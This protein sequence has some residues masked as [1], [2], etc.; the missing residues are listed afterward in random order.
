MILY[1]AYSVIQAGIAYRQYNKI[2]GNF[3]F[4]L[5]NWEMNAIGSVS[6]V[7]ISSSCPSGTETLIKYTWP[8][9]TPGCYCSSS[10][11]LFAS[12]C[13]E[14][15]LADG[16][17]EVSATEE[18]DL[19]IY[20]EVKYCVERITNTSFKD[21]ASKLYENGTCPDNY[22]KCGGSIDSM[23]ALC[24]EST[25]FGGGCPLMAIKNSQ[26][27]G[28]QM[29]G[30]GSLF[31]GSYA[32]D[33]QESPVSQI[34]TND[35]GVCSM[36]IESTTISHIRYPLAKR[37]IQECYRYDTTFTEIDTG[38]IKA[39]F[40]D[41]NKI[42]V[43]K[44]PKIGEFITSDVVVKPFKKHFVGF[45]PSCRYLVSQLHEKSTKLYEIHTAQTVLFAVAI[46]VVVLF[47]LFYPCIQILLECR[48]HTLKHSRFWPC[49]NKI[50]STMPYI[51]YA[52]KLTHIGV[53]V[54]AVVLSAVI[55]RF[56]S[57]VGGL[58]CGDATTNDI[59]SQ[60]AVQINTYVFRDNVI[61]L[62]VT[63]VVVMFDAGVLMYKAWCKKEVSASGDADKKT[64]GEKDEERKA[65]GGG[66]GN[67]YTLD[68][69]N[70]VKKEF[71][72]VK[73][74][75]VE[76]QN[77]NT[78]LDFENHQAE[79]QQIRPEQHNSIPV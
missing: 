66:K 54:W 69:E 23:Y 28:M 60:V 33:V 71:E 76:A 53:L 55:K 12:K 46:V 31:Y 75:P 24:V 47:S 57:M 37:S 62:V 43:S 59:I 65:E 6:T 39:T 18:K 40:L 63:G 9:T 14:K 19:T 20:K 36:M 48:C 29:L 26:A 45:K 10:N 4:I 58:Q 15:Q 51:F 73:H 78:P 38:I 67:L 25:S 49:I 32:Q 41:Q 42:D 79:L 7:S 8:G 11:D 56:F 72:G 50:A 61:C 1:G 22:I 34:Y 5:K 13:T 70:A 52:T 77:L 64:N 16:C 68:D 30:D 44:F 2:N 17:T 35:G 3:N 27:S 21:L 74:S